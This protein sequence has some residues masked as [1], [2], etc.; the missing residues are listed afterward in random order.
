MNFC[1]R[2]YVDTKIKARNEN[3]QFIKSRNISDFVNK[4]FKIQ[5]LKKIYIRVWRSIRRLLALEAM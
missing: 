3:S 4:Y 1:Y 2:Q 5:Y